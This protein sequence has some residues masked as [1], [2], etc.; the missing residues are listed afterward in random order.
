MSRMRFASLVVSL[1][2]VVL[3]VTLLGCA[4]PDD[5][6]KETTSVRRAVTATLFSPYVATA[7]G[8]AAQAVAVGDL[9]GDGRQDVAVT[10]SGSADPA[11]DNMLHVFLQAADGT[12]L[13]R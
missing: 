8:S 11:N 6:A 12:L 9:D 2:P 3:G 5:G 7:T 10:T 13:P 4:A 1:G